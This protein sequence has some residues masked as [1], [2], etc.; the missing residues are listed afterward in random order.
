MWRGL[1]PRVRG[2]RLPPSLRPRSRRSIP[3]RAGE[4]SRRRGSRPAARVYPRACGGTPGHR[5]RSGRTRGLSPRV[6]GN[7]RTWF[8]GVEFIRSIPARAGEPEPPKTITSC[9]GVYPRACGGTYGDDGAGASNHGLSPRVRGNPARLLAHGHQ[10]RSI[11]ARA[12]EPHF[13]RFVEPV[14]RVYPRACGGTLHL[15]RARRRNDGLSPRV[16][17][18]RAKPTHPPP[19]HRSIPARAGEPGPCRPVGP[20]L[21][22]YPRACGGTARCAGRVSNTK[23]LSPRVRGNPR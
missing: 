14:K 19:R 17:G 21:P 13:V 1:S 5:E 15:L 16:R 2:N 4:P 8:L 6:R 23:G 18:N 3:A 10:Q 11:P 20:W 9:G 7:R 12:G 22:V